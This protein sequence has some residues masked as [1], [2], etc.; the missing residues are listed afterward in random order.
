M[1]QGKTSLRFVTWNTHGIRSPPQKFPN[2]LRSLSTLQADIVFIQE[3]HVGP[4]CY[5]IF[6]DIKDWNVYFTVHRSSSKGVAI[7]IRKSIPFTYIC[8]DE[9]CSGGYIVLFCHL[10]GELY[11][12]VNVYNHKADKFTLG[13]LKEYLM[14]V[15][16]GVLVVGGDFN[17]VLHPCFDRSPPSSRNSPLRDILKDF[18]VSLNLR[19]TWSYKHFADEG[20]TRCQNDS[21]SRIDM[22]FVRNDSLGQ[23]CNI[24]V[25]ANEIS[26]H[27]PVVL[28]LEVQNLTANEFPKVPLLIKTA[29]CHRKPNRIAG[30]ISGAEILHAIKTLPDLKEQ[31][32]DQKSVIYYKIHRCQEI[33]ILK[34]NYNN[35]LKTNCVSEAFKGFHL[36]QDKHTFNVEYL[37]FSHI[38]AMRLSAYIIPYVKEV[39]DRNLKKIFTLTI[40]KGTQNIRL[41][42][43]E[44]HHTFAKELTNKLSPFAPPAKFRILE[45][46]LPNVPGSSGELKRL[47]PGCPLTSTILNLALN[48]L[49][50]ILN[51]EMKCMSSVCFQRQALLIHA[52]ES[53]QEKIV[54]LIEK[55][56]EESGII[57]VTTCHK[58]D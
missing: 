33:E 14:E 2:V 45:H 7:L 30:K 15:G 49:D 3:T 58:I 34:M 46:L 1:S 26:D 13:R 47:L 21:Q 43:L 55:F 23:V 25:E 53:K 9:D 57:F 24:T 5:K 36:S 19:D 54:Q 11:T 41:S 4:D 27:N 31:T 50:W 35:M 16:E 56:Q 22:F 8:H 18:T 51:S 6:T 28:E 29:R 40:Y 32:P 10:Y 39:V 44:I 48:K 42:F 17:T 20:F 38:V 37:I 52:H 12:L